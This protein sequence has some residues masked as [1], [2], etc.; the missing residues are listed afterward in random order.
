MFDWREIRRTLEPHVAR[1]REAA[2]RLLFPP[3]CL[4][5]SRPADEDEDRY[6]CRDC[7]RRIAFVHD[8]CCP[9]CGHEL[10]PHVGDT[11]RCAECRNTPLRFHRAVA[12]AHH[13]G[14]ARHL[15]LALKFAGQRH[16]VIPLG[17]LLAARIE[18]T[19]VGGRVQ[20]IVPVPLH[21]S[22]LRSR[23]FNQSAL[24]ADDLA[25]RTGLPVIPR[26][27]RRVIDTPP[28]TRAV[29]A[30]DRRSN[31]KGAFEVAPRHPFAGKTVLV[32]DD[33]L[34]T[35]AT[36]SECAGALKRAGAREVYVA[37]CTRRMRTPPPADDPAP[38][39]YEIEAVPYAGSE[40][41]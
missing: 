6:L 41:A 11:K 26:G 15:V 24:I 1:F 3:H 32:V 22:R 27:L 12:A 17:K 30:A 37:T 5:C 20:Q 7:I 13:S 33:V 38:V 31:V 16:N 35:G 25:K 21:R 39:R 2:G 9:R 18:R 36:T 40:D 29:T 10:G 28:Q 8:P 19:G 4:V 23:G 34:T 14:A